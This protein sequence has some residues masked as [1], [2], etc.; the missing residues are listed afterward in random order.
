MKFKKHGMTL[1]ECRDRDTAISK[2]D[3]NFE[4]AIKDIP[5]ATIDVW[6]EKQDCDTTHLVYLGDTVELKYYPWIGDEVVITGIVEYHFSGGNFYITLTDIGM[7][8]PLNSFDFRDEVT[9][10][11]IRKE[12]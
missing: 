12:K 5:V 10:I 6:D 3:E 2:L 4:K 7:T 9:V 11:G 1:K 8:I